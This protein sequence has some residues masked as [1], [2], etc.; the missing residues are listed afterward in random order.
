MNSNRSLA[1][2]KSKCRDQ[3]EL[4]TITKLITELTDFRKVLKTFETRMFLIHRLK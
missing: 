2:E 4:I 1:A 3:K